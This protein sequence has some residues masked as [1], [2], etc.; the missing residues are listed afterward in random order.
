MIDLAIALHDEYKNLLMIKEQ[1]EKRLAQNVDLEGKLRIST[2]K[3]QIMYY[4]RLPGGKKNGE[5]LHKK[6]SE[7][8]K[9]LAQKSYDEKILKLVTKRIKQFQSILKDYENE[10]IEK[11]YLS[12]NPQRQELVVP[13]KPTWKQFVAQWKQKPYQ[14]KPF[15][16]DAPLILTNRHERVRSKTE[17]MIANYLDQHNIPYKYECPLFLK[18]YGIIYPDFTLLSRKT[19]KEVYWEHEGRMDD[20]N[21]VKKAIKKIEL[22]QANNILVGDRLIL[23]FETANSVLNEDT[24]RKMVDLYLM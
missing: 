11:I 21:Y 10:E 5:Y 15:S 2:R 17:R 20:S 18:P 24:I 9:K 7:L 19:G 23:T 1:V 8:A 3:N 4:H 14:G 13:V 16:D 6:D 12:E 22:Y